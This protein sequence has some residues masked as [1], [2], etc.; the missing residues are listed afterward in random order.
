[1]NV[2]LMILK[3]SIRWLLIVAGGY[4]LSAKLV[5]LLAGSLQLLGVSSSEAVVSSAMLG[6]LI[7][8]GIILWATHEQRWPRIIV[9][10]LIS[11]I[12]LHLIVTWHLA[13][14]PGAN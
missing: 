1:M 4:V 12:T 2:N 6:F 11:P 10:C 8:L 3:L 5:S 7:Y 14:L 13:S 9:I